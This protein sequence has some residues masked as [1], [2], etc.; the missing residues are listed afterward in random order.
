MRWVV[1]IIFNYFSIQNPRQI[2]KNFLRYILYYAF[3]ALWLAS[4]T[5]THWDKSPS[6][7]SLSLSHY[8]LSFSLPYFSLSL[9]LFSL[10]STITLPVNLT[11]LLLPTLSSL[12]LIHLL[13][14]RTEY[15]FHISFKC[16]AG[17]GL[18]HSEFS[19]LI[20]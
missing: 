15:L 1:I 12:L 5:F 7:S 18:C 2:L 17:F 16:L 10:T 8:Y 3:W 6:L 19:M 20:G 13:F 11:F 9:R 14:L 4:K